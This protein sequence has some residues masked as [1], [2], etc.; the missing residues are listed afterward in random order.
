MLPIE[1]TLETYDFQAD[2]MS[3][4]VLQFDVLPA[5]GSKQSDLI[6]RAIVMPSAFSDLKGTINCAI[7]DND[8]QVVGELAFEYLV[9]TPL[10]QMPPSAAKTYW[11]ATKVCR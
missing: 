10:T 5:F 11:K 4:F 8:L 9:V 1:D 2:D 7:L 3:E 6:G